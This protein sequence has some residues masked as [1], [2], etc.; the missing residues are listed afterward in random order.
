MLWVTRDQISAETRQRKT[1]VPHDVSQRWR[2]ATSDI[3][4]FD[5]EEWM[6]S[7]AKLMTVPVLMT[8]ISTICYGQGPAQGKAPGSTPP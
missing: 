8:V 6:S 3:L 5:S 4:L 1:T 7:R 2:T